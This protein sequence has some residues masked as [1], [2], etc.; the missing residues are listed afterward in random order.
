MLMERERLQVVEYGNRMTK[1][2]LTIGTAGNISIC[3]RENN[4][5]VISPSGIPYDQT[6]PEDIV[7]MD[8]QGNVLEG[9]NKPSSEHEL[10]AVIYRN[11]ADL[12]AVVHTHSMYCT[13]LACMGK[14]LVSVHYALADA[15]VDTIPLV[16]Y[17]T[18]GTVE[19]ANAVAKGLEGPTHGLLLANHGMVACG[20][21]IRSAYGLALTMEWCAQVQWRCMAAG[22][23]NVLTEEQMAVVMEAYKSY[24]QVRADGT[25]PQ[26]YNG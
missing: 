2:G 11:R 5:M 15:H 26:G 17:H 21:T 22:S 12:S 6:K 20:D 16:D 9:E 14:P 3:D 13:T 18:F 24:G 8:L 25:R 1:D 19:L 4:R 23:M 7:V 10:H